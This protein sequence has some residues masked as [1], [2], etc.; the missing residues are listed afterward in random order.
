MR[1]FKVTSWSR[2]SIR[3]AILSASITACS[4]IG[5][6]HCSWDCNFAHSFPYNVWGDGNSSGFWFQSSV[7]ESCPLVTCITLGTLL[8]FSGP[9]QSTGDEDSNRGLAGAVRTLR[10]VGGPWS[11]CYS[12]V[13][14]TKIQLN[15]SPH[16]CV[17]NFSGSLSDKRFL[18]TSDGKDH[19]FFKNL[20]FLNLQ[21]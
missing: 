12:T 8:P 3:A 4:L 17:Y 2:G 13:S 11:P 21:W 14:V 9:I 19:T 15:N 20:I 5:I 16:V 10:G 7:A 6:G 1:H 18:F